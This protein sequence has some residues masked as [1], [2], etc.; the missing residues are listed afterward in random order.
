[1][2]TDDLFAEYMRGNPVAEHL[3][4]KRKAEHLVSDM[5]EY[6]SHTRPDVRALAAE[7]LGRPGDLEALD[8]LSASVSDPSPQVRAQVAKSLAE[9]GAKNEVVPM[10]AS[11]LEDEDPQV[12]VAVSRA[13]RA[14]TGERGIRGVER[15]KAW[16]DMH[17]NQY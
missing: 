17:R 7:L 11:M 5:E 8:A 10:L 14:A 9:I 1:M 13:L 15:W 4:K 6:L 2:G 16:W 12:Q 3:L